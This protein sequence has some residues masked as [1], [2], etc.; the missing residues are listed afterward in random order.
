MRVIDKISAGEI[1][2]SAVDKISGGS[3][4]SDSGSESGTELKLEYPIDDEGTHGEFH[5]EWILF[6]SVSSPNGKWQCL[7]SRSGV[8]DEAPVVLV[9]DVGQVEHA[10]TVVCTYNAAVANTGH[11][12]VTDT[13]LSNLDQSGTFNVVNVEGEPVIEHEFDAKVWKCAITETGRYAST[14][15]SAPDRSVYIFDTDS[16]ELVT[17]FESEIEGPSQKFGKIDGEVVLYLLSDET[18]Y[19][20]IDLNGNVVWKSEKRKQED[21]LKELLNQGESEMKEGISLLEDAYE[22]A[23]DENDKK[24]VVRQ[25]ADAHWN[26]SREIKKSEGDSDA[27]WSHLNEAKQ[28]YMEIL[29]WHDGKKGVAK[30]QRKQAKYHLNQGNEEMALNLLQNIADL[31]EEYD[32]QLLTDADKK[33]IENLS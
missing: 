10:F 28:Y 1:S 14:A 33:K 15:S 20:A 7:S 2:M 4:E 21:H 16:G 26:L 31:E 3:S 22:L 5:G 25:L 12:A 9:N 27:W 32:V 13:G 18:R 17:K 19:L 29:P 8:V 30:T 23:D 11:I 24:P 6:Q